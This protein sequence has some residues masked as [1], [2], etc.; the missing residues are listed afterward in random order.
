MF[1]IRRPSPFTAV[2]ATVGFDTAFHPHHEVGVRISDSAHIPFEPGGPDIIGQWISVATDYRWHPD[3][4]TGTVV[5]YLEL[6]GGAGYYT[7]CLLGDSCG[8]VGMHGEIGAGGELVIDPYV[9]LVFGAHFRVLAGLF[10]NG[11]PATLE[12]VALAGLR[13]G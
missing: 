10:A 3:L 5:P 13:W 2:G 8:G 9:S 6:V 7:G 11:V 4:V 12:P 1:A